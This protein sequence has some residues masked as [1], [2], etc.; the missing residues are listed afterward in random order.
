M[1]LR[2]GTM[3]LA[4][5]SQSPSAGLRGWGA[6]GTSAFALRPAVDTQSGL[7]VLR[8]LLPPGAVPL[9]TSFWKSDGNLLPLSLLLFRAFGFRSVGE[10][11]EDEAFEPEDDAGLGLSCCGRRSPAIDT[12]NPKHKLDQDHH[13][14]AFGDGGFA[15]PSSSRP[16]ECGS[17]EPTVAS[18]WTKRRSARR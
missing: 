5:D 13:R 12:H 1:D 15:L 7:W 17:I 16:E 8:S 2:P 11:K 18:S 3:S 14:G 4:G 6:G 10:P 9:L